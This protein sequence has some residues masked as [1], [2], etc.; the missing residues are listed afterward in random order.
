MTVG[1]RVGKNEAIFR[2]INERIQEL[3]RSFSF[4][5]DDITDYVC[6]CSDQS[7]FVSVELTLGEFE[8]V[9]SEP[10]HFLIAPGHA[11]HPGV[12]IVV[13]FNDRF[14]VVEKRG[15]AG[16]VAEEADPGS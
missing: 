15:D 3:N 14:H 8:D 6:E 1:E 5:D 13:R 11:W 16:E 7:C 4:G 9:R 10:T 12:E 2:E